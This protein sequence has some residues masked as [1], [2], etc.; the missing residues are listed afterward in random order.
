MAAGREKAAPRG[1]SY[2][3]A[4]SLAAF[5]LDLPARERPH[6]WP[7]RERRLPIA[8]RGSVGGEAVHDRASSIPFERI[9]SVA[10]PV[11]YGIG[12]LYGSPLHRV[13]DG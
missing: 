3:H 13:F 7:A 4:G 2:P 12:L 11:C 5:W 6:R 10:V 8:Q 9:S 1:S